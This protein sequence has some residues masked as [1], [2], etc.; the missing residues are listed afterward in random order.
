MMRGYTGDGDLAMVPVG[1]WAVTGGGAR[2]KEGIAARLQEC[3]SQTAALRST[4]KSRIR[5][6]GKCFR[7]KSSRAPVAQLDRASAFYNKWTQI[8]TKSSFSVIGID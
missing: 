4:L 5:S 6:S 8:Q 1:G 2:R 7:I 3:G